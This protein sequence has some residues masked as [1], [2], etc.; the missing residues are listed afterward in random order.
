MWHHQGLTTDG[1][2]LIEDFTAWNITEIGIDLHYSGRITIS[3]S[4]LLGYYEVA[5]GYGV[6]NNSLVHDLTLLN[7]YIAGFEVGVQAALRRSTIIVGGYIQA[8]KGVLVEK[9]HDTTRTVYISNVSFG[10]LSPAQLQGRT[11]STVY[12]SGKYDFNDF[13]FRH[14]ETLYDSDFVRINNGG[15]AL[16][17]YYLE[18]S[19][20]FV[21]FPAGLAAGRVPPQYL[22]KSNAQLFAEYG[23]SYAGVM[24]A[25]TF[26]PAGING[27][28]RYVN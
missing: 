17:L 20:N 23:I 21:P 6:M 27:F 28:A 10:S 3:N 2:S 8:L 1:Q 11:A 24:A 14:M 16:D 4:K 22:N 13:L 5:N 7:N 19:P 15:V 25:N 18:Q 12:M 9:A 26:R